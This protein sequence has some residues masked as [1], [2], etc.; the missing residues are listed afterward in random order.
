M[1]DKSLKHESQTG[2]NKIAIIHG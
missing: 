1:L 2:V